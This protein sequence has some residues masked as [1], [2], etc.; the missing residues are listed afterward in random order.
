MEIYFL[1][2]YTMPLFPF[3][4]P[5]NQIELSIIAQQLVGFYEEYNRRN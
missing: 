3:Y 5:I 1:I 2:N 4:L